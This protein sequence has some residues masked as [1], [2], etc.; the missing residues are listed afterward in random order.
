MKSLLILL[1]LSTLSFNLHAEDKRTFK[2]LSEKDAE[3][4]I[5]TE[6]TNSTQAAA[7][8]DA[9]EN[10]Q[11]IKMLLQDKSSD[12]SKLKTS[13]ELENC[14]QTST[15]ENP[16]IDG[17]G[18]VTITPEV[19]TAFGRGGWMSAGASYTFFVGF[20]NAGTG[21]FFTATHMVTMSEDAEAQVDGN[22]EYTGVIL[23]HLTLD[24]ITKLPERK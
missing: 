19:A 11:F 22:F 5:K 3:V 7:Y 10:A 12:L 14:Q 9:K 1:T 6:E 24:A 2:K 17:C 18:E 23:K 15:D 4:T 8:V 21:H 20:T 16:W 13:I